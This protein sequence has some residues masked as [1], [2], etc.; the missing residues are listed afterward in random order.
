MLQCTPRSVRRVLDKN[1]TFHKW[2]AWA[3]AFHTALHTGSHMF[4]YKYFISA[5][6]LRG[7]DGQ[8]VLGLVSPD[9]NPV[10]TDLQVWC[11][12]SFLC[13]FF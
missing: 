12:L 8:P 9:F 2:I 1:L 11:L 3:I 13:L 10:K 5:Y 4:N 6:D 7:S